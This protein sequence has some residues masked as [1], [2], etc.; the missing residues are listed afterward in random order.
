MRQKVHTIWVTIITLIA[1]TLSGV[2]NSAPLMP[3]QMLVDSQMTHT[4]TVSEPHSASSHESVASEQPDCYGGDDMS[5]EHQCCYSSCLA[6]YSVINSPI[7]ELSQTS[8]L[9]LIS[10]EPISRISAVASDLF[11]PPIA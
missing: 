4:V 3:L 8:D 2:V 5:S 11:R 6:S 10:D 7:Y 1:V 9:V